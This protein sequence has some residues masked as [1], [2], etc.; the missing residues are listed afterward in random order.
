MN[1]SALGSAAST[2]SRSRPQGHT[3]TE[4]GTEMET[5]KS[6]DDLL[7]DEEPAILEEARTR[8]AQ[9]EHYHRDGD[10]KT[11]E[12]LEALYR[13]LARALRTRDLDE[14]L[15]HAERV[16]RERCAAGFDLAEVHAAFSAL[17]EAIW[18]RAADRLS[19]DPSGQLKPIGFR[20]IS[21]ISRRS[22][23]R[24]PAWDCPRAAA[25]IAVPPPT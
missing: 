25:P 12:R 17:E 13:R 21:N 16:A 19:L 7:R 8:V 10:G 6:I 23:H 18:R 1:G 5:T 15:A 2:G 11:V 4:R 24:R 20:F 3:R 9:L 14:L 22:L